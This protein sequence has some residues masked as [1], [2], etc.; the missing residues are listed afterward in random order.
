[1]KI[2]E[3][4][5][6]FELVRGCLAPLSIIFQFLSWWSVLLVEITTDLPHIRLYGITVGGHFRYN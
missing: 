3:E 4:L 1:M 6:I 2:N 5:I